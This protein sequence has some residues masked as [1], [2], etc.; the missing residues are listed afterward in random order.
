MELRRQVPTRTVRAGSLV[1]VVVVG[2]H[3]EVVG[4][5]QVR[6]VRLKPGEVPSR[7]RQVVLCR[8]ALAVLP[9]AGRAG[10]DGP[11]DISDQCR[12]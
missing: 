9:R 2:V 8:D 7:P 1:D 5:L 11:R 4:L 3:S 6:V 12:L 10:V